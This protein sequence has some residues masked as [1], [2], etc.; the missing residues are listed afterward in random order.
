MGL[1]SVHLGQVSLTL[2]WTDAHAP[3]VQT[4]ASKDLPYVLHLSR[5]RKPTGADLLAR[6][7]VA[8]D[9]SG[10]KETWRPYGTHAYNT[11]PPTPAHSL[12]NFSAVCGLS[13]IINLILLFE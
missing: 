8:V 10:N 9:D 7:P 6:S 12:S 5:F 2:L 4:D 1:N 13:E 3:T 11:Y